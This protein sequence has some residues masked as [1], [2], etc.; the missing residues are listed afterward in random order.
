MNLHAVRTHNW[1]QLLE[2]LNNRY[3]GSWQFRYQ[4]DRLQYAAFARNDN[5]GWTLLEQRDVDAYFEDMN[6]N[7][8]RGTR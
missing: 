8:A 1:T 7:R 3:R 4:D 2:Y 5:Y 6:H